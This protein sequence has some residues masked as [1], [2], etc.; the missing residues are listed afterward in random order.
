MFLNQGIV[1]LATLT[2]RSKS[3]PLAVVTLRVYV[4]DAEQSCRRHCDSSYLAKGWQERYQKIKP[5][6]KLTLRSTSD[7]L[8]ERIICHQNVMMH[9]SSVVPGDAPV[10]VINKYMESI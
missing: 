6:P 8:N 1:G 7:L 9:S 5:W 3:N 2:Y 10:K 4:Y